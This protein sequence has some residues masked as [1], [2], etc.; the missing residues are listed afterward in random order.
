MLSLRATWKPYKDKNR[1]GFFRGGFCLG[2][3]ARSH[4]VLARRLRQ[5]KSALSS[6]AASCKGNPELAALKHPDFYSFPLPLQALRTASL[7]KV[8]PRRLARTSLLPSL[9][10]LLK[11]IP[12]SLIRILR[13]SS[14]L[15]F[16]SRTTLFSSVPLL[17][18]CSVPLYRT[19]HLLT[20]LLFK[21]SFF[22][23][24][25]CCQRALL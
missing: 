9:V 19:L 4:C 20:L 5:N 11:N 18:L 8:L 2:E 14:R 1:L 16:N 17:T 15:L 3:G 13:F 24:T 7:A 10:L 21:F 22:P 23:L 25:D 12:R 6:C